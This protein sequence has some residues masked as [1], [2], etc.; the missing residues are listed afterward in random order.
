MTE[1]AYVAATK[2]SPATETPAKRTAAKTPAKKQ[3]DAEQVAAAT[4]PAV[5]APPAAKGVFARAEGHQRVGAGQAGDQGS[6]RQD[7]RESSS[8]EGRQSGSGKGHRQI[9]PCQSH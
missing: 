1:R 6:P 4:E 3:A 5:T 7:R 8:D 9:R 2:A